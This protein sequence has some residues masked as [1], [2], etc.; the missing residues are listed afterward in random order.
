MAAEM[1][2]KISA[3]SVADPQFF[4]QSRIVHSALLEIAKRLG[5]ALELLLIE[6]SGLLAR[7]GS[8]DPNAWRL[9]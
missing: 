7:V 1:T 4:D 5:V 2:P 6:G 9:R 8:V 3:G